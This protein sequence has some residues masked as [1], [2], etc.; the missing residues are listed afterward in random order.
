MLEFLVRKK[1]SLPELGLYCHTK[2]AMRED[3]WVLME[4][5]RK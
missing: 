4:I 1:E 5:A 3:D 2:Y